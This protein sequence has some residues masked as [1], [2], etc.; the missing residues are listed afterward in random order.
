MRILPR[1][2]E[3]INEEWLDDKARFSYDGL[4]R[5]R[6]VTPMV[7]GNNGLLRPC[8]W[9]DAFYAVADR[10]SQASGSQVAAL[11]GN[12]VDA[13]SLVALKDLMNKLGSEN[14]FVEE[15]FPSQGASTD[16]RTNYISNASIN[17]LEEADLVLLIGTNPRYEAPMYNTRIRKGIVHNELRV[18]LVGSRVNLSY[19]YDY[20]GD[21]A[22]VLDQLVNG[23]HEYSKILAKAKRPLIVLGSSALQRK[24]AD[25]LFNLATRLSEKLR[26]QNG[27]SSNW[28]VFNVLQRVSRYF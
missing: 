22:Q 27:C 20:L 13:E 16:L 26:I 24:D 15:S 4:R 8:D 12:L 1:L 5:Q 6:L 19:E 17:S 14:V 25:S 7:R 21:S 2:N 28:K 11:A 10:L 9:E 18:A 3:D 23:K